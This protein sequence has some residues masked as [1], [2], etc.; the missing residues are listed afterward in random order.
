MKI[1]A[2][3]R[4][5]AHLYT[6]GGASTHLMEGDVALLSHRSWLA[7]RGGSQQETA[8]GTP[9]PVGWSSGSLL[10]TAEQADT[11][12]GGHVQLGPTGRELLYPGLPPVNHVHGT[13]PAARRLRAVLSLLLEESSG[14]IQWFVPTLP[15]D[16]RSLSR[17]I[18]MGATALVRVERIRTKA[19]FALTATA[20][21]LGP[22]QTGAFRDTALAERCTLD[23]SG[24]TP[25]Y[26]LAAGHPH[27]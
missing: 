16:A 4:G 11:V 10:D 23:N 5:R 20:L 8:R 9:P 24:H 14:R 12:L 6:D 17:K 22:A 1:I 18:S 19:P 25:M 7:L 21:G 26:V 13:H 15:S 27:P 2:V 3:L